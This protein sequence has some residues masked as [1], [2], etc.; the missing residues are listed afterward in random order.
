M[1]IHLLL[2][3]LIFC[4]NKMWFIRPSYNRCRLFERYAVLSRKPDPVVKMN[5]FTNSTNSTFYEPVNYD[6]IQREYLLLLGPI[7]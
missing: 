4:P 6:A 2:N 1:N 5:N 3:S 7:F